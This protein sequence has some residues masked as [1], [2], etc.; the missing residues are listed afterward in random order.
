[1]EHTYIILRILDY[2]KD[3]NKIGYEELLRYFQRKNNMNNLIVELNDCIF[4]LIIE[5]IL[6]VGVVYSYNSSSNEYFIDKE[7]LRMKMSYEN[8]IAS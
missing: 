6:K 2:V 3:K 1:M 4:D 5:G 7:K 8:S